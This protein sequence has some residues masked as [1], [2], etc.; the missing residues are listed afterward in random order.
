MR[1]LQKKLL[2]GNE[3]KNSNECRQNHIESQTIFVFNMFLDWPRLPQR[4]PWTAADLQRCR[5]AKTDPWQIG[6]RRYRCCHRVSHQAAGSAQAPRVRFATVH[7]SAEVHGPFKKNL[8]N[9]K[10]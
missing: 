6:P 10:K 3:F 2:L 1:T 9:L 5:P 4:G 8:E 7:E